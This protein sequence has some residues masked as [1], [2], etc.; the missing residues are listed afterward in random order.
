M[1]VQTEHVL[2]RPDYQGTDRPTALEPTEQQQISHAFTDTPSVFRLLSTVRSRR[3]GNELPGPDAESRR[4]AAFSF[5]PNSA[6]RRAASK[7]LAG[8]LSMTQA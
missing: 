6:K 1:A 2:I 8:F 3:F 7:L 5:N 4:P